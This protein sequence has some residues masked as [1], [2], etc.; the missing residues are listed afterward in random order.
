MSLILIT[1]P[2]MWTNCLLENINE[3][4]TKREGIN[5]HALTLHRCQTLSVLLWSRAPIL[6]SCKVVLLLNR[7]LVRDPEYYYAILQYNWVSIHTVR[8]DASHLVSIQQ[9]L[10]VTADFF[11]LVLFSGI[12]TSK[13]GIYYCCK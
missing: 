7:H 1:G 9:F 13:E 10:F 2:H 6:Q 8:Q 4:S 3:G 12:I 11:S 5:I